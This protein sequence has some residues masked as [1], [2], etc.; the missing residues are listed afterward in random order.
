M[1]IFFCKSYTHMDIW[2]CDFKDFVRNE[3]NT[4]GW[5]IMCEYMYRNV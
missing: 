5:K 2:T 4:I 3:T 1:Y